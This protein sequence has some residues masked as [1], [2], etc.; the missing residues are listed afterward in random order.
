MGQI[1]EIIG[2]RYSNRNIAY[3]GDVTYDGL[4]RYLDCHPSS[5]GGLISGKRLM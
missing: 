2:H 1:A 5:F 3:S 4:R